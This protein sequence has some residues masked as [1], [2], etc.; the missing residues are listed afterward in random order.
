MLYYAVGILLDLTLS[1]YIIQYERMEMY[2]RPPSLILSSAPQTEDG[3][4]YQRTGLLVFFAAG[5]RSRTYAGLHLKLNFY[6]GFFFFVNLLEGR[7]FF[8]R[9]L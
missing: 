5:L 7:V 6:Q 9:C 4:Q 8:S 3:Q 2:N 1:Y